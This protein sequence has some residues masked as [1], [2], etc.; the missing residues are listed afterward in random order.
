M[1]AERVNDKQLHAS[2]ERFRLNIAD[3]WQPLR[4]VARVDVNDLTP[5]EFHREYVSKSVPVVLVNAMTSP[6][7]QHV[8]DA[9]RDPAH[10]VAKATDAHV[11]VDITPFG[12]GDAV[13]EL[14]EN[15]RPWFVMP[16][17]RRMTLAQFMAILADRD[18]FDGVPYL[19]HQNDSL[20]DEFPALYAEVPS[21]LPLGKETFGND[22]D[23]VNIWI[24]DERAISSMHKDHYENMYCVVVGRKHFTLLPP[25]DIACLYETGYPSARYRHVSSFENNDPT[26]CKD[27]CA[28]E[29]ALFHAKYPQHKSWVIVASP[30]TGAT[31]W[32]P[33]DPLNIDQERFPLAAHLQPLEVVVNAGEVLYLPA[34]W[35]HRATQLERTIS[36][37]YWHDMEFD[38]RYVYYTL[39]H[40][41]ATKFVHAKGQS[42]SKDS[43]DDSRE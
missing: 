20:R 39:V 32:I 42:E 11:T 1:T 16:E 8:L 43:T 3:F 36:V 30:G 5:L 22:P 6:E 18:G 34:M 27:Y 7:W 24:G 35:Y 21:C 38:C 28:E 9:W 2:F 4:T 40:E 41:L 12:Y 10:L 17:E 19:S 23:A 25:A 31:P 33:V 26:Q 13:L 37:N 29:T 14:G 15:Q